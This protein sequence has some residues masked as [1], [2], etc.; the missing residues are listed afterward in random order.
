MP[1]PKYMRC[2]AKHYGVLRH[3]LSDARRPRG[4]I[5]SHCPRL[6]E[7]LFMSKS[8]IVCA[9]ILTLFLLTVFVL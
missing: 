8:I 7:S 2:E 4:H 5:L 1:T 9:A 6:S 3:A